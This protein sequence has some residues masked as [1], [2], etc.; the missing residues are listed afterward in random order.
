[1]E[2]GLG[3]PKIV[4]GKLSHYDKQWKDNEHLNTWSGINLQVYFELGQSA[5]DGYH[6][7]CEA[8]LGDAGQETQ[9]DATVSWKS[10]YII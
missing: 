2:S 5:E 6:P 10:I 4:F 1:M 9:T 7:S 8:E 3:K